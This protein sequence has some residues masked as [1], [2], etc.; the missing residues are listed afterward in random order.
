MIEDSVTNRVLEKTDVPVE[1]IAG[2]G[3]ARI[4]R[5]GVP[6]TIGALFAAPV[7]ALD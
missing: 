3:V 7:L 2:K 5:I 1:V 6:A 4:E